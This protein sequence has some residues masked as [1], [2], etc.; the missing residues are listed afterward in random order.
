MKGWTQEQIDGLKQ[1]H[2]RT[3]FTH[4]PVPIK[5][6]RARRKQINGVWH[7]R[8]FGRWIPESQLSSPTTT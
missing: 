5:L 4:F 6:K 1:K 2:S 8:L 3:H 7:I